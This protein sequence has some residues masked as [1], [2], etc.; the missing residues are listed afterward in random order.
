MAESTPEATNLKAQYTAQV[1]ADLERNAKEQEHVGAEI[2]A[3]HEQLDAL[4]HDQALLVNMRQAL[5]SEE[6]AAG[7]EADASDAVAMSVPPQQTSAVPGPRRQ[8]KAAAKTRK[9]A[10]AGS[11]TAPSAVKAPTLGELIR[12]H[13]V[14]QAE[15]RSAAEVTAALAEAHPERNTNGKVVRMAL[16][17]LVAKGHVHRTKQ[18][19]SVFYSVADAAS[20]ATT[21]SDEPA[22]VTTAGSAAKTGM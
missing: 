15:P 5:G 7:P 19:K 21:A 6:A 3:L 20:A 13:L 11:A 9:P 17:G 1:T 16:E 8:R 18:N 2:A 14:Q 12:D 22:D 4:R 10:A